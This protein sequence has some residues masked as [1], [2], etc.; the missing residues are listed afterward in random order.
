[1][2]SAEYSMIQYDNIAIDESNLKTLIEK[3]LRCWKAKRIK[4][5]LWYYE[6]MMG[7]NDKCYL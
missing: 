2:K 5:T 7:D 1:M 6:V 4:L 3:V